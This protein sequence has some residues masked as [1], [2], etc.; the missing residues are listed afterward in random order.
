MNP[1]F[2]ILATIALVA[3][4]IPPLIAYFKG[5]KIGIVILGALMFYPAALIGALLME[6]DEDVLKARRAVK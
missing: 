4:L 3:L 5:R 6:R 2:A 1:Q